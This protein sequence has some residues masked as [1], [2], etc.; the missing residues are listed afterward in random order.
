[1]EGGPVPPLEALACGI[2]IVIP[3]GVG[4]MNELPAMEG[5][6]HYLRG[7]YE[8]MLGAIEEALEYPG[9]PR[10]LRAVVEAYSV[11]RWAHEWKRA[12][13][14]GCARRRADA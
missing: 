10:E 7:D 8:D 6:Y 2:P 14:V 9:D 12:V 11:G 4:A 1:V 13:G 5:V 3:E